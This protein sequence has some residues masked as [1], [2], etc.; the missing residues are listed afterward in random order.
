MTRNADFKRRVRE[1]MARTGESYATAR[2]QSACRARARCTSP[3]ATSRSGCWPQIGIEAL[4]WRDALHEGPVTG[5]RA[6]AEFLG[7]DE[8][9]VR[10]AR[11]RARRPQRRLR[12]V[13]R[14]RSLRPAPARRDPR[15]AAPRRGG[16]APPDRRARRHRALRRAR[17]ARAGAAARAPGDHA[18]PGR[19]RA[20]PAGVGRADRARAERPARDPGLR[21]AALHGRGVQAARAGV[22]VAPRRALAR[23]SDGCSRARPA[24][25]SSCSSACGARSSARSWAT[26]SRSPRLD[27]LAPLLTHEGD[28]LHLNDAG[29]RVLAGEAEFVT[30]R[31]IGGVHVTPETPWRWDDGTE[32]LQ[33]R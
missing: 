26:R 29:E 13:V 28:V 32:T 27:R 17:P 8:A 1:R 24:R 25:R 10:G 5:R 23:P 19:A 14:G 15:A 31:W 3:T 9:R 7:V 4:A 22:P 16:D 20:R 21:G 30:E 11:P 18:H 12:P 2:A 33:R 6:R